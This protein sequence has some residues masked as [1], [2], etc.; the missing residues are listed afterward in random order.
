MGADIGVVASVGLVV[1]TGDKAGAET[2]PAVAVGSSTEVWFVVGAG[3]T[4][5]PGDVGA[6][7][8]AGTG[9]GGDTGAGAGAGGT[10]VDKTSDSTS[11]PED[12]FP[13]ST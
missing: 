12:F 4:D 3:V 8:G 7:C 5:G 6:G 11:T 13:S 10:E 2:G 9:V 1:G